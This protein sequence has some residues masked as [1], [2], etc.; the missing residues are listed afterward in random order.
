MSFD[1]CQDILAKL[2][3][4]KLIDLLMIKIEFD[5]KNFLIPEGWKDICL[6]D[7]EKWHL[8]KPQT[9][10]D[11]VRYVADV[12][13]LDPDMLME[14]PAQLFTVVSEAISFVFE[15][16]FEPVNHVEIDGEKHFVSFSEKLTLGEWVD[17]EAVLEGDSTNKLSELLAVLCRPIGEK[18]NPDIVEKRKDMFMNAT[19][20]KM[21]PLIS[22]FLLRKKRS[23][24]ILNH[25]SAVVDQATRFLKDTKTFAQNGDGIKQLPIWQRIRYTYL[26]KSLVKQLSK[27]S[28]SSFTA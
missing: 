10:T 11:Y 15:T 22:F 21:L 23:D 9:K 13:K 24:E 1:N 6:S 2:S 4:A 14:A 19:C 25:Y 17:A 26:T 7:Y 8:A 20:D 28:D 3:I 16:D 5:N 18:Y 27:F 12:C